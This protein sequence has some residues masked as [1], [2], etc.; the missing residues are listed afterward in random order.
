MCLQKEI[1][2]E[3]VE[4]HAV[5]GRGDPEPEGQGSHCM[6]GFGLIS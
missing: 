2:M 3:A 4:R 6:C 5:W 1:W